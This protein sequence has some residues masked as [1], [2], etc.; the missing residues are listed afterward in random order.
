MKMIKKL[1]LIIL[2]FKENQFKPRNFQNLM[3]IYKLIK[4]PCLKIVKITSLNY[5]LL[6]KIIIVLMK[7]K[8]INKI[9]IINKKKKTK[10]TKIK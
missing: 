4:K 5:V 7:I 8:V 9:V 10:K 2:N 6:M 3:R 1:N